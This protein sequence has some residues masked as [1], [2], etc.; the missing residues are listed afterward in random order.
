MYIHLTLL[1][2]KKNRRSIK[3]MYASSLLTRCQKLQLLSLLRLLNQLNIYSTHHTQAMEHTLCVCP[4]RKKVIK[5]KD[6]F[7]VD[8]AS[9]GRGVYFYISSVTDAKKPQ[10]LSLDSLMVFAFPFHLSILMTGCSPSSLLFRNVHLMSGPVLT[11]MRPSMVVVSGGVPALKVR[12]A[13]LNRCEIMADIASFS[14]GHFL[15]VLDQGLTQQVYLLPCSLRSSTLCSS[16]P[17]SSSAFLFSLVL[18]FHCFS[19]LNT[20]SPAFFSK[21]SSTSTMT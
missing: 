9:L 5:D 19:A 21:I 18:C 11:V 6:W 15:Q 20:H 7:F 13:E 2:I 4:C 12:E 14:H 3:H 8:P 17:I 1:I 16:F 10:T